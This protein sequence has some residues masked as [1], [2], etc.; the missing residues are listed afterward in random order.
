M[1][2]RFHPE[3]CRGT[4]PRARRTAATLAACLLAA[5]TVAAE[6]PPPAPPR[7]TPAEAV[8]RALASHPEAGAARAEQRRAESAL[9]ATEA[10][11]VPRV[12]LMGSVVRFQEPMVVTPI[13][14]LDFQDLPEFDDTLIQGDLHLDHTLYDG[15]VRRGGVAR[16]EALAGAAATGTEAVEQA[17]VARTLGTYLRVLGLDATLAAADRR[18]DAVAAERRRVEQLLEVGRAPEVDL[19]R[20]EAALASARASRVRLAAMLETA[21]RDLGRLV[22]EE[23]EPVPAGALVPIAA[24]AAELPAREAL[25]ETLEA[26][27]AVV[28]ARRSLDAAE[29]AVAVARGGNRPRVAVV[30]DVREYGSSAGSFDTEWNAG[31]QVAVPVFDGGAR[32]ERV[33]QAEAAR[34]AAAERLRLARLDARAEVDR[35]VASLAEARSRETALAEA[36][37]QYEEVA[38]IEKL[39]LDTGV[40]VQA[41]Y[42]DAEAALLDARAGRVEAANAMVGA[43]VEVARATGVLDAA[44]VEESLRVAGEEEEER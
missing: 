42:L 18:M 11:L 4:R 15:G 35:A 24:P 13:H 2:Q 22:G 19:R 36:V 12:D 39:R 7:L 43:R 31:V 21:E 37:A 32:D 25:Y 29:A 34:D 8:A 40:G 33:A 5:S 30:G 20:A 38:R 14:R 10:A 41:D 3:A 1:S 44:W 27:P 26:S 17:L 9:A 23:G 16:D 6:T 28:R